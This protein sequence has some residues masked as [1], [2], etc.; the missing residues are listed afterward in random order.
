MLM[1]GMA[2]VAV[3]VVEE[4]VVPG[5]GPVELVPPELGGGLLVEGL[6][7][8]RLVVDRLAF[9]ASSQLARP[10]TWLKAM[11]FSVLPS[12]ATC[13]AGTSNRAQVPAAGKPP[14]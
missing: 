10:S 2:L 12:K 5:L 8:G 14:I 11:P 7:F 13:F 9:P 6:G 4:F 3:T 1:P